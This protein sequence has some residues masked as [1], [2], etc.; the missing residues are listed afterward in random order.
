[1]YTIIL[2]YVQKISEQLGLSDVQVVIMDL[3]SQRVMVWGLA[4]S[5]ENTIWLNNLQLDWQDTVRHELCHLACPLPGHG[6]RFKEL[7]EKVG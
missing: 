7:L 5:A 4:S 2:Q 1:M 3:W 6:R